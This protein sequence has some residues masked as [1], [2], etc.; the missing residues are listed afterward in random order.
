MQCTDYTVDTLHCLHLAYNAF[1]AFT[2]FTAYAALAYIVYADKLQL[3]RFILNFAEK[4]TISY[5]S[6]KPFLTFEHHS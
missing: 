3:H 6:I 5:E 4:P 1:T 2:A